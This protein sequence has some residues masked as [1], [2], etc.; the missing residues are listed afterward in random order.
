[1]IAWKQKLFRVFLEITL[2]VVPLK[3]LLATRL[4]PQGHWKQLFVGPSVYRCL[5]RP[6]FGFWACDGFGLGVNDADGV[7]LDSTV[8][9]SLVHSD[10]A[11]LKYVVS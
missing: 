4:V 5:L 2:H 1:M 7:G 8:L 11:V 9:V 3:A 10:H 6:D